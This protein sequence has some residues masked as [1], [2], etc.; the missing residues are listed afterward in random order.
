[1]GR[2]KAP[3]QS[4]ASHMK[5]WLVSN[6]TER[7]DP[8]NGFILSPLYDKLFD[9]GWMTF[10]DDRRVKI[11]QWLRED[12]KRIGVK[13]GDFIQMLPMDDE[14]KAYMEYHRNM[15]FKG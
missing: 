3:L 4:V 13:D 11:S 7:I 8:K 10:T 15:V 14:R 2:H 9:Q 12:R 5:P 6:K 1:M